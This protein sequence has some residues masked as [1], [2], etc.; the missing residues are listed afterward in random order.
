MTKLPFVLAIALSFAATGCKK[1]GDCTAAINH[2]MDLAKADMQKMP[3]MD[4]KIV[5]KLK[6][7]GVQHCTDDKWPAE[8]LTCMNDAKT[9]TDAQ[10][11]YSKLSKDQQDKM[12]G[13]MMEEMMKSAGGGKMGG[14]AG[15]AAAAPA[16]GGAGSAE[17]TMSG[18]ATAGGA[19][20][21]GHGSGSA[22]H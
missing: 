5:D 7:I 14:G 10:A 3:G 11:C 15:S 19:G 4:D 13:A 21:G 9:E 12:N 17:P 20:S 18:S 6:S 22:A 1:K 8:V 16:S 2:S